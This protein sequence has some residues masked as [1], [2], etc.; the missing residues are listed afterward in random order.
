MTTG[1]KNAVVQTFVST[2]ASTNSSYRN[3]YTVSWTGTD[4]AVKRRQPVSRRERV[5]YFVKL[6]RAPSR[7]KGKKIPKVIRPELPLLKTRVYTLPKGSDP[8]ARPVQVE[9]DVSQTALRT[10]S[11]ADNIF[12]HART[13]RM[14]IA[15][16]SPVTGDY[17]TPHPFS[18]SW[19]VYGE[20]IVRYQHPIGPQTGTISNS[21]FGPDS[22]QV[23]STWTAENDYKLL[24]RLRSRV[25]GSEFNLASFLG[26]EGLDT[27]RFFTDT[28]NRLYRSMAAARKL[29]FQRAFSTLRD[30]GRV[31]TNKSIAWRKQREQEDVYRS[32]IE[33][34]SGKNRAQ[35]WWSVPA[36]QWLEYHLAI[37]PLFGD[38]V[39]AAKQLAHIT[40]MP[41]TLKVSASVR[42]R[43]AFPKTAYTGVVWDGYRETRKRIIAYFTST[44]EPTSFLGFQDPEVTIWNA[45]PLSFVAD[46][47]CDI[48][49]YLEARA[50]AKAFP[51]GTY[52]TSTKDEYVYSGWKSKMFQGN[53]VAANLRPPSEN[54]QR[55]GSFTRTISSSLDVPRPPFKPLGMFENWQRATTVAS[56][57]ATFADREMR[58]PSLR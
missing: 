26:A 13:K 1:T 40:Q 34:A 58:I 2:D 30:W 44:P 10:E 20:T 45:I 46:Y 47:F 15:E 14:S 36:S 3:G 22:N 6:E 11:A 38:C 9:V 19:T 5:V 33:A 37:E 35:G 32:I 50:T 53:S 16:G 4:R 56:L 23:V 41:R 43:K 28:A 48:G 42:V 54:W 31:R 17:L 49:G 18:K 21:G 55:T 24:S 7:Y 39:A 12:D 57:L 29:D 51:P 52:V 8:Q 27:L 25:V